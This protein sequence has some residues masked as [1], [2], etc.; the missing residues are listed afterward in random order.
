MELVV[1]GGGL[2]NKGGSL[3][4]GAACCCTSLCSAIACPPDFGYGTEGHSPPGSPCTSIGSES[5]TCDNCS[6]CVSLPYVGCKNSKDGPPGAPYYA[7]DSDADCAPGCSCVYDLV[8]HLSQGG[9]LNDFF[10]SVCVPADICSEC[11]PETEDCI[12]YEIFC[13][14]ADALESKAELEANF[15][16][17]NSFHIVTGQPTGGSV[18][19]FVSACCPKDFP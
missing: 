9:T 15:S 5:C 19:Y 10:P 17:C 8:L 4:T 2:V 11:D 1:D 12:D 16:Y 3:G 7:C 13:N 18:A 6:N 14:E